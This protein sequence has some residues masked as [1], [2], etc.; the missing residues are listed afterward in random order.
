MGVSG[1]RYMNAWKGFINPFQ[2]EDIGLVIFSVVVILDGVAVEDLVNLEE[3][4]FLNY[5]LLCEILETP[6][7]SRMTTQ[8]M[9]SSALRAKD[10]R[11]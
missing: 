10:D 7:T 4:K 3:N 8:G 2:H 1:Y 11:C 6:R 5:T 9:R